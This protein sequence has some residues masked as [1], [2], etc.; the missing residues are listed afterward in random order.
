MTIKKNEL[1]KY[2]Y[3]MAQMFYEK[4]LMEIETDATNDLQIHE[5]GEHFEIKDTFWIDNHLVEVVFD[6]DIDID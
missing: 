6:L 1:H 4:I 3:D 2:L 5:C